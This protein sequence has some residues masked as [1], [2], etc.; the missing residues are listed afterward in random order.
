MTEVLF[1]L[2]FAIT[3]WTV[4]LSLLGIIAGLVVGFVVMMLAGMLGTLFKLLPW[5]LC[6]AFAVW[7]MRSR[8]P[9]AQRWKA[10]GLA[11]IDKH[12]RR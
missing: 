9:T 2:A 3:L 12:K 6:I 5:I 10:K 1:L 11:F 8:S 4:G 7:L